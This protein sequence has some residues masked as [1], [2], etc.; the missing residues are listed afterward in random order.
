VGRRAKFTSPHTFSNDDRSTAFKARAKTNVSKT[1]GVQ[2]VINSTTLRDAISAICP[3]Y[4][5]RKTT[6]PESSWAFRPARVHVCVMIRVRAGD[7][8]AHKSNCVR[9]RT[10]SCKAPLKHKRYASSVFNTAWRPR[11]GRVGASLNIIIIINYD[12]FALPGGDGSLSLSL[13]LSIGARVMECPTLIDG[14]RPPRRQNNASNYCARIVS[15]VSSRRMKKK[16][17]FFPFSMIT[18]SRRDENSLFK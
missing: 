1:V 18:F 13:S 8:R 17:F 14:R 10:C 5:E 12:Y 4:R 6:S 11:T 2:A 15:R 9:N 3:F 7:R 16:C